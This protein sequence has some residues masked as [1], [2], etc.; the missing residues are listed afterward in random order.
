MRQFA[1]AVIKFLREYYGDA[2]RYHLTLDQ[3]VPWRDSLTL[4][5]KADYLT[6]HI[7]SSQMCALYELY[8]DND[9]IW[10]DKL[11]ELIEM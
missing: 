7:S 6:I 11:Q 9:N 8:K 2:Y 1:G 4:E 5:V 10:Q 3:G